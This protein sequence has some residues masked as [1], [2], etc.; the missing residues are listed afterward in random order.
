MAILATVSLAA[1]AQTSDGGKVYVGDEG[2]E[3]KVVFLHPRSDGN[4]LVEVSGSASELDGKTRLHHVADNGSRTDFHGRMHGRDYYTLINDKG[5]WNL[6][7]PGGHE[8]ALKYDAAKSKAL[9]ANAVIARYQQQT[10][11]GSLA[12]LEKFDRGP[13]ISRAQT[14]LKDA[15]GAVNTACGGS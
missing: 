1:R 2:V 11:D 4:A 15:A 12:A 8:V 9:D 14:K 3:V 5:R 13:R 10:K 6:Y 7:V